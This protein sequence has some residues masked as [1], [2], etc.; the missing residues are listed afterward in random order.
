MHESNRSPS[1]FHSDRL[2]TF[3]DQWNGCEATIRQLAAIGH[4][5]LSPSSSRCLECQAVVSRE[6]SIKAL[7]LSLFNQPGEKPREPVT[8]HHA[9]CNGLQM[10]IPLDLQ[11]SLPGLHD[12]YRVSDVRNKFEQRSS[13]KRA[14]ASTARETQTSSLFSLPTEIRLEIYSYIL[15]KLE[16]VTKI[17]PLNPDSYR[18]VTRTGYEKRHPRD[19][20][21]T[22]LLC[23]C[24]AVHEEALDLLYSDRT[25]SFNTTMV[26]YL[27]LRHIGESGRR[28]LRS[29]DVAGGRREDP[30]AFALL[31][32]CPKLQEITVRLPRWRVVA[33]RLPLWCMEGLASLVELNELH[34]ARFGAGKGPRYLLDDEITDAASIQQALTRAMEER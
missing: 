10:R 29:V 11:S 7:E 28:L 32:C 12:G 14:V 2:K 23:T 13:G 18:I 1:Y 3:K 4:V 19:I 22:N 31:A 5:C 27:F 15:P 6:S 8:F 26:L 25:Y 16:P 34:A 30:I 17:L 24:R 9:N 20:T 33:P 21:K